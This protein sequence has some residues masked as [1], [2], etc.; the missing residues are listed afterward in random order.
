MYRIKII[1]KK[2]RIKLDIILFIQMGTTCAINHCNIRKSSDEFVSKKLTLIMASFYG[3]GFAS[4][5]T[6]LYL[7]SLE[8]QN[9]M[10]F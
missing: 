8:K 4:E 3:N 5:S 6:F 7:Y 1:I 9:K 10:L 2:I